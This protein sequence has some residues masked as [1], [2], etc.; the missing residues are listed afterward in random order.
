MCNAFSLRALT[1]NLAI[2]ENAYEPGV[3]RAHW[4]VG[5]T[6]PTITQEIDSSSFTGENQFGLILLDVRTK[7]RHDAARSPT[8]SPT[9]KSPEKKTSPTRESSKAAKS[10]VAKQ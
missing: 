7:L 5:K 10:P 3:Q 2:Y 9:G 1:S 4:G 6:L 8:K